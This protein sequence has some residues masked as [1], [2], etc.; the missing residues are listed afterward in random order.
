MPV[1]E[2]PHEFGII[3]IRPTVKYTKKGSI[4]V[5]CNIYDEPEGLRSDKQAVVEIVVADTGCGIQE[6]KLAKMFRE[7][8]QVE[9]SEPRSNAEAGVGQLSPMIPVACVY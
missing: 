5:S 1:R 8:E 9:I 2:P 6:D 4:S 7:F 3:I